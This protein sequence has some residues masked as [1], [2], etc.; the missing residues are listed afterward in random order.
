M[1]KVKPVVFSFADVMESVSYFYQVV[2]R[3]FKRLVFFFGQQA[4][5]L[6]VRQILEPE[7]NLCRP[8]HRLEIPEAPMAFFY[9]WFQLVDMH[10]M[11]K[12]A[13]FAVLIHVFKKIASFAVNEF[14][15]E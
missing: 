2:P 9:I 6:K 14:F 10:A 4:G 15:S 8:D 7:N 12:D 13:L 3:V 5:I 11:M 1:L